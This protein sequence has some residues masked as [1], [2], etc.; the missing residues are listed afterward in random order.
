MDM[1]SESNRLLWPFSH[2]FEGTEYQIM[3]VFMDKH[4]SR[5]LGPL[6]IWRNF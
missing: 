3:Y 6:L 1:N 5:S 2:L 4:L